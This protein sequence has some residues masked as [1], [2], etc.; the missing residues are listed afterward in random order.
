MYYGNADIGGNVVAFVP[1]IAKLFDYI[2]I[3]P[4]DCYF[5]GQLPQPLPQFEN[6]LY[7]LD[8]VTWLLVC[9]SLVLST[10][11]FSLIHK[12]HKVNIFFANLTTESIC[13]TF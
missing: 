11:I 4:E 12:L 2:I 1:N 3:A 9:V 5:L 6:I 13:C 10:F 8:N 7:P